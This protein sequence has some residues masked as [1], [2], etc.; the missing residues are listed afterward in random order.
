M[1]LSGWRWQMLQ[2]KK[3]VLRGCQNIL[4][5]GR[6]MV[7]SVISVPPGLS[8]FDHRRAL[9]AGP[10]FVASK[11]SYRSL[12]TQ[13]GWTVEEQHDVTE[14]FAQLTVD[15]VDTERAYHRELV[16]SAGPEAVEKRI[17]DLERRRDALA[18]GLLKRELFVVKSAR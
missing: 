13:T 12:L 15:R 8:E 18:D 7:F 3:A 6:P 4:R 1:R 2:R 5:P 11:S 16:L 9:D 10:E 14:P 17:K